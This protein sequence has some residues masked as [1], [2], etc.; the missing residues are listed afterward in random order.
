LTGTAVG[1]INSE[2]SISRVGCKPGDIVYS[3]GKLGLGNAYAI[4]KLLITTSSSPDYKPI[5]RIK[6]CELISKY[7]SC[8]MDTSDGLIS[9]LDQLMRLNDV[10]FAISTDLEKMID[11]HGLK[12]AEDNH[13]PSWLLFA[14]QHGEFELIFT[15]PQKLN[16]AFLNETS[17]IGFIPL[18]LGKVISDKKVIIPLY[19]KMIPIDTAFIRNLPAETKGDINHYLK[20]LLEYDSQLNND[21]CLNFTT[22]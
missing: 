18:E 1:I 13:I 2:K 21:A 20:L 16:E 19:G 14:G 15:I 11:D 12:Y 6:E 3:S 7:A 9:T 8:C 10:G 22:I 4:S 5:A 17:K